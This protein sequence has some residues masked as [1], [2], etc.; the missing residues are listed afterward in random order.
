MTRKSALAEQL[1]P[2][3]IDLRKLA[4]VFTMGV[5]AS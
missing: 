1:R 4:R 2:R 5:S 3:A